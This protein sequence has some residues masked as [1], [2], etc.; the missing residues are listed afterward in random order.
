MCIKCARR[1][2]VGY[3]CKEC[4]SNQQ[5]IFYNANAFD[6][7]IQALI[8]IVI[9]AVVAVVAIIF[10][11]SIFFLVFLVGIPVSSAVG[12]FIADLA[13]R[14]VGRRRGKYSWM[15]VGGGIVVGALIPIVVPGLFLG[16][17]FAMT[18][19]LEQGGPLMAFA[20]FSGIF[21]IGWWVYVVVATATAVGR[22]R[23]G[24]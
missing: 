10:G 19:G 2:P 17:L 8:S 4:V 24:K 23:M 1:T 7:V 18:G 20:G 9:S 14:A 16:A 21:S 12:V 22:L 6:P 5:A 13:H 15:A 3:R 11:G